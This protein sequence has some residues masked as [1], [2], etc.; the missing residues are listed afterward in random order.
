MDKH[1]KFIK[2]K[3][4]DFL[5]LKGDSIIGKSLEQLGSWEQET[6]DICKSVLKEDSSVIEVGAHIGTHTIPMSHMCSQGNIFAFEMQ[7]PI[8]Q[9]LNSNIVL[10]KCNNVHT[11][12]EV[13]LDKDDVE[14][15]G[16]INY[17][18]M[19]GYNSGYLS[20]ERIKQT[21]RYPVN[22]ITL[23]KKFNEIKKLDLIKID[24]E[25]H[26]IQVLKGSLNLIK[27]FK[28]VI[29][30]E[31]DSNRQEIIDLFPE[32]KFEESNFTYRLDDKEY[33]NLMLVGK[34]I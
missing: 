6:L 23:D 20:Y 8:F 19:E 7:K 17:P 27:K 18:A 30:T 12:M 13:V 15:I 2:S 29:L 22:V 33:V 5:S 34:P 3:V 11:Y 24:A 26:E 4:G 16:E 21:P 9:L 10:N 32:Y 1:L 25:G 14:L 28:P 31:Y